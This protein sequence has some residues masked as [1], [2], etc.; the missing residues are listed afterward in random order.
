MRKMTFDGAIKAWQ[1]AEPGLPARNL[2]N[3]MRAVAICVTACTALVDGIKRNRGVREHATMVRALFRAFALMAWQYPARSVSLG[4]ATNYPPGNCTRCIKSP[5]KCPPDLFK[6]PRA[7]I[8]PAWL[9]ECVWSV[10]VRMRKLYHGSNMLNGG[11]WN[12]A[13]RFLLEV[14]E[15]LDGDMMEMAH[16]VALLANGD[17]SRIAR[18][19]DEGRTGEDLRERS[20][21]FGDVMLWLAV[22]ANALDIDLGLHADPDFDQTTFIYADEVPL[23]EGDFE[24]A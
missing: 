23:A 12:V 22:M 16:E 2:P 20:V 4:V 13:T 11:R 14:H 18:D 24:K 10:Q 7:A 21:E 9:E 17:A 8:N 1:Q 19:P 5:C 6:V 15:A 3:R